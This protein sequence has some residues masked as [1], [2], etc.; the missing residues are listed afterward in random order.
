VNKPELS[1]WSDPEL[2]SEAGKR[3]GEVRRRKATMT[4][5]QRALD[6]IGKKLGQ[7]TNELLKAAMGEGDFEDLKPEIRVAAIK[8][9]MEYRLGKPA[10][11]RQTTNDDETTAPTPEDLFGG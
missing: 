1:Y 10:V 7:L 8:T 9:L 2:A 3:S 11:Q 5:E 4:P 6:S